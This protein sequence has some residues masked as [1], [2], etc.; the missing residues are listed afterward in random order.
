MQGQRHGASAERG[1]AEV[2]PGPCE[3][4]AAGT[5]S[6]RLTHGRPRKTRLS[7]LIMIAGVVMLVGQTTPFVLF[8]SK[9]TQTATPDIIH[10]TC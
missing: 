1:G 5:S 4:S 8:D 7:K 10:R 2:R 6:P 9:R 3:L